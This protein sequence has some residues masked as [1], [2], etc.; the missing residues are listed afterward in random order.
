MK[1]KF[2][3]FIAVIVLIG[4]STTACGDG[5]SGGGPLGGDPCASGHDHLE[6]LICRRAGCNH[7]YA[8]GDRGPGGGFIFYVADSISGRTPFRLYLDADDNTGIIA[9]YLEAAPSDIGGREWAGRTGDLIPGL[10]QSSGD[11]TDWA[12]GRGRKNTAII[13][14]Y[15]QNPTNPPSS[16]TTP[17]TTPAASDCVATYNAGG[18]RTDWFLPSKNELDLLEL[19][20]AYV[21]NV[22]S[23]GVISYYWSSS[24]YNSDL[25]WYQNLSN[26]GQSDWYKWAPY[27]VRAI[28]AF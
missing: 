1:N 9:H 19:N 14:A 23:P 27:L 18:S 7:Q 26:G 3:L 25:V 16:N 8:L 5:G 15:G 10:S 2:L 17:F 21:G 24:Q 11:Q 22:G 13:I 6:S 4:F 20:K 12:I 28:R